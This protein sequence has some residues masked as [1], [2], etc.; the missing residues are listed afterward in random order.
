MASSPLSLQTD[1]GWSGRRAGRRVIT[2][3][4]NHATTAITATGATDYVDVRY[5]ERVAIGVVNGAANVCTYTVEGSFDGTNWE[6]VAYGSGSSA[7]YTQAAKTTTAGD[8]DILFLPPAD[9]FY[10]VRVN[11][12]AANANGCTF[13]VYG[14]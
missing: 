6:T 8:D 2:D 7:A 5:A 13:T 12:S 9:F 14:A 11:I 10:F 3:A 1:T 4:T